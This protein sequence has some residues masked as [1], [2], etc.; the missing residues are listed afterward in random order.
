MSPRVR[1]IASRVLVA[2]AALAAAAAVTAGYLRRALLEP[3]QFAGRATAALRDDAVRNAVAREITSA[4]ISDADRDLVAIG[5]LIDA[6]ARQLVADDAFASLFR[7]AVAS[8][9]RN[10]VGVGRANA[11]LAVPDVGLLLIEALRQ[12]DP[13]LAARLPGDLAATVLKAREHLSVIDAVD[14]VDALPVPTWVLALAAALLLAA[15]VAVAPDRR[16][17]VRDGGVALAAGG[18]VIVAAW[19]IARAVV[20]GSVPQG[21]ERDVAGAVWDA[22]L[23]DLRG[24][25][26]VL[27][28]TGLVLA[29]ASGS[30]E[31]PGEPMLARIRALLLTRPASAKLR[32][33]RGLAIALAGAGLALRSSAVVDAFVV[34]AGLVLAYAGIQELL[35]AVLP[36]P[37]ARRRAPRRLPVPSGR[38]GAIAAVAAAGTVLVALSIGVLVSGGGTQPA[39]QSLS[40]CN[41][42]AE[43]CGRRLDEVV[44]AATHNAMAAADAPGWLMPSQERGIPAQLQAGVR[45]LLID[46]HY[47]TRGAGGRVFTD[48][49][50][51]STKR[52]ELVAEFGRPLVERA[53]A[54][55]DRLS[56][57]RGAQ[58]RIYLCHGLCEL[59]ATDFVSALRKIERFLVLN[60]HEVIVIVIEDDGPSPADTAA[61]FAE[62]G[63]LKLVYKGPPGPPSGTWPRLRELIESNQRVVVFGEH[64]TGAVPWY[65]PA[66][67]L[68]SDTPLPVPSPAAFSCARARGPQDAGLLLLNHWV[69]G[70]PAP[71]PSM[72]A[73]VNAEGALLARARRCEKERGHVVNLLA[74]DFFET[75]G[76]LRAVDTLNG[77]AAPASAQ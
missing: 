39:K 53:L 12:A 42:H 16:I 47:G 27:S 23:G 36:R 3:D 45:G 37:G 5:P 51:S 50:T 55:R 52:D 63:L 26:A 30:L 71:R 1:V 59:G 15:G 14:R 49:S 6:A 31:A 69:A 32:A 41:G 76:L 17:G 67:A 10:V 44:L 18:V 35:R 62:S 11:V 48:L 4:V 21:Q 61:A 56:I 57:P 58:R 74:V 64:D 65:H 77:V 13:R 7:S 46:T 38:R 25:A 75:G 20:V 28:V 70:D 40:A 8:V 33:L 66:F 2:L 29:A 24:W 68:I 54:L 73:R 72:A 19:A 60:P 22:F 34:A 9:Q 43:L